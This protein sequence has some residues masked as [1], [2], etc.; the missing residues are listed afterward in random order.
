MPPREERLPKQSTFRVRR[1]TVGG[2]GT[3][4]RKHIPTSNASKTTSEVPIAMLYA[5]AISVL[6][7]NLHR[8]SPRFA[9]NDAPLPCAG[10]YIPS[11]RLGLQSVQV[12]KSNDSNL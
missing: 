6:Y 4:D 2:S 7:Q 5:V 12:L 1:H 10:F 8:F 3:T 11:H 9:R